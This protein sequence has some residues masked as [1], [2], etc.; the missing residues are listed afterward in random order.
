MNILDFQE[1]QVDN[2][3]QVSIDMESE[4]VKSLAQRCLSQ[5]ALSLVVSQSGETWT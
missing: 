5:P 2:V 1:C 4:G 3:A